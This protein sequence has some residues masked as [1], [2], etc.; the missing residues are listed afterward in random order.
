MPPKNKIRPNPFKMRALS[1]TATE[2][3]IYDDIGMWGMTAKRF[4]EDFT[5]IPENHDIVIRINSY[6]GEVFD[7]FAIYNTIKERKDKV[8]VIID[9]VAASIAGYIPLAASVVKAH[10]NAQTMYHN[11]W[12]G[13]VGNAEDMRKYADVL[14]SMRD[15]LVEDMVQRMGWSKEDVVQFINDDTWLRAKEGVEVGLI[16]EEL[17]AIEVEEPATDKTE[18][19]PSSLGGKVFVNYSTN[20][21]VQKVP[22][23][24]GGIVMEKCPHCGLEVQADSKFCSHCGKITDKLE[25]QKAAS[26]KELNEMKAAAG[27]RALD[28]VAACKKHNVPEDKESEFLASTLEYPEIAAKILDLEKPDAPLDTNTKVVP[29]SGGDSS[30]KFRAH[31][32]RCLA[33]AG[34]LKVSDEERAEARKDVPIN[35][36][37]ALYRMAIEREGGSSAH[38]DGHNLVDAVHRDHKMFSTGS[39]DLPAIIENVVNKSVTIGYDTAETTYEVT[40]GES[41]TNDFKQA[42]IVRS[43]NITEIKDLPE[44][45][46][47]EDTKISDK[48]EVYALTNKGK[49]WTLTYQAQ[50]NDDVNWMTKIPMLMGKAVKRR[51]NMDYYDAITSNSLVGPTMLEDSTAFFTTGH[52]NLKADSGLVSVSN[53]GTAQAAL[54]NMAALKSEPDATAQ[55]LGISGKYLLTGINKMTSIMQQLGSGQDISQ[56]I[57]GVYNPYSNGTITPVF[58]AYLQAKLTAG[59]VGNAWYLMADQGAMET[60]G[61]AFLRGQRTPT[62]RR[63]VSGVGDPLGIAYD[64]YFAWA[65]YAA[66][67]RGVIYNDGVVAE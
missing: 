45:G 55:P 35:S 22:V 40:A 61:I 7:G 37:H 3:M 5:S 27:K 32:T 30:D 29:K 15:T 11:P 8:T 62:F 9:G 48:K 39:S 33:I 21:P 67:Y 41:E 18:K 53:I 63:E 42:S 52:G 24:T 10:R 14:D 56:S 28:I 64:I 25:A 51:I 58:D 47:F 50:V 16:D 20:V 65:V 31:A 46:A 49:K 36:I 4:R 2:I 26:A 17:D 19:L 38:L 12:G 60:F 13:V 43:S 66:D 44:G 59:S 23:N 54:M 34:G 1:S 57:P 6:G